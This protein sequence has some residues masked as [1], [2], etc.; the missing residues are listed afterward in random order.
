[1]VGFFLKPPMLSLESTTLQNAFPMLI[2]CILHCTKCRLSPMN[3]VT[4]YHN[5]TF[6]SHGQLVSL[7]SS[8]SVPGWSD[9]YGGW[10]NSIS[11]VLFAQRDMSRLNRWHERGISQLSICTTDTCLS[12]AVLK[13][14]S[15]MY[16]DLWQAYRKCDWACLWSDI[17]L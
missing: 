16:Q 12:L 4:E 5:K 11:Y 14:K 15:K 13:G 6:R 3:I 8:W 1:M 17:G 9:F 2:F 7:K 10:G